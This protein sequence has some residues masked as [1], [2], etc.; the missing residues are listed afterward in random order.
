M[1]NN[2]LA[3]VANKRIFRNNME[4]DPEAFIAY[5]RG[6]EG[7]SGCTEE[8]KV[9]YFRD[10]LLDEALVWVESIPWDTE[11]ETLCALFLRRFKGTMSSIIHIKKLAR[12]IYEKGSFLSHLYH[13]KRL[14]YKAGLPENVLIT[15]V[16]NGLPDDIGGFILMNIGSLTW[17]YIYKA[18]EGLDCSK[19][20]NENDTMQFKQ[21]MNMDICKMKDERICNY[22][23]RKGHIKDCRKLKWKNSQ[24]ARGID[25]LE[26]Q[27]EMGRKEE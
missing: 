20:S 3:T 15:F 13:M 6:W 18:C 22:C 5:I 24:Q 7:V 2:N 1:N 26:D 17:D 19:R 4:D 23:K 12:N 11:F 21:N 14:A 16:L 8:G 10:H 27:E 9:F 25:I